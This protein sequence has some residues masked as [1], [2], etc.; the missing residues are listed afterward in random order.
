VRQIRT[1]PGRPGQT[2]NL[3]FDFS[4]ILGS[5]ESLSGTPTCGIAVYTGVD[6]SPNSLL[7]GS[8]TLSGNV[9]TQP[10]ALTVAST[11]NIYYLVA[12]CSTTSGEILSLPLFLA[13]VPEVT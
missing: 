3:A 7:S 1:Q 10:V 11:G 12:T 6:N 13:V 9:V 5:T 2:L 8:P 4:S